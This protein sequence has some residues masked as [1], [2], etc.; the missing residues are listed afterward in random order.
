MDFIHPPLDDTVSSIAGEYSFT[1]EAVVAHERGDVLY[2][3]GFARMDRSCCGHGACGY[4]LVAGHVL[5]LHAGLT[6][7]GR[8][9]SR[10]A[11]VGEDLHREVSSLIQSREGVG[12]VHFL[13]PSGE[14]KIVY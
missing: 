4:A 12:Q 14:K 5:E 10:V 8:P 7:G 1:R 6:A 13:L 3:V 2:V 9:V 11:P